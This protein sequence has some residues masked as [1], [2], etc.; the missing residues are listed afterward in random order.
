MT[1]KPFR[2]IAFETESVAFRQPLVSLLLW[3][4]IQLG[5]TSNPVGDQQFDFFEVAV[6][7]LEFI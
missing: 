4:D 1:D 5:Y 3:F 7:S 6:L 2:I